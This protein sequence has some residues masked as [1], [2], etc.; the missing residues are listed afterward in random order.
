MVER[1][2]QASQNGIARAKSALI[3]RQLNQ[4]KLAN[5]LDVTRQPISKFFNSFERNTPTRLRGGDG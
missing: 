3:G 1:S 4:Q 5:A 2:L